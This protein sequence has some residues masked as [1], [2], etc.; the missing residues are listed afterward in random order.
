LDSAA[1]ARLG[2]RARGLNQRQ[3][4]RDAEA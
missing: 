2:V 3:T 1:S 4:R